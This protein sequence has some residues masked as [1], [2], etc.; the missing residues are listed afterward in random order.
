MTSPLDENNGRWCLAGATKDNTVYCISVDSTYFDV[1]LWLY[2]PLLGYWRL[3]TKA[4]SSA[5]T[6]GHHYCTLAACYGDNLI[7]AYLETSENTACLF[8][9]N[10]ESN[11]AELLSGVYRLSDTQTN[12]SFDNTT[13][14]QLTY[15][16]QCLMVSGSALQDYGNVFRIYRLDLDPGGQFV[17]HELFQ[18]DLVWQTLTSAATLRVTVWRDRLTFVEPERI[19]F[20]GMYV[21]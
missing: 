11:S 2:S 16:R 1:H 17:C 13:G 4:A 9:F 15:W 3:L 7:W 6:I 8:C 14:P 19:R 5:L 12:V 18:F 20:L 21:F 10:V